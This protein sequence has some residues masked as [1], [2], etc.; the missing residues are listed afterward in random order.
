MTAET[1]DRMRPDTDESL[2]L[3]SAVERTLTQLLDDALRAEG[4]DIDQWRILHLLAERGGCPMTVVAEH[5]LMLAPRLSKLVDRMVSANLVI[6]RPDEQDRRRVLIAVSARGRQVLDGWN[7]ATEA[8]QRDVRDVLGPDAEVLD[9][10]LRRI[11]ARLS[12]VADPV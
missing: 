1:P 8:A 12:G 2:R 4:S 7:A 5:T 9:D 3:L 11:S 6:R 10:A